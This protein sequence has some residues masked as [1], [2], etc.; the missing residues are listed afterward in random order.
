[1][2]KFY[3]FLLF[4]FT[5]SGFS[6]VSFWFEGFNSGPCSKGQSANATIATPTN[7]A[8]AITSF[9]L[10]FMNG[11]A[12][13]EWYISAEE[14]GQNV[15]VCGGVTCGG[16]NN[17]TLHMSS[18]VTSPPPP[19]ID[20]GT[21]YE[22]GFMSNTNK[23]AETPTVNCSAHAN[24]QLSFKIIYG[25]VPNFDYCDLEYS[26]N[27][28]I[29]WSVLT[30]MAAPNNSQ[31]PTIGTWTFYAYGLPPS[32]SNN[33][34]VKIGFHWY[35]SDPTGGDLSIGID[36]IE[37]SE[38]TMTTNTLVDCIAASSTASLANIAVGNTSFTWAA[39]PN[40]VTFTPNSGTTTA[41]QFPGIGTYTLYAYGSTANGGPA[42][43]TAISVVSVGSSS[44]VTAVSNTSV[45]CQGGSAV[46][47][48]NGA[49]TYTWNTSAT[50]SSI[51]VSPSV[52]TTYTVTGKN[53]Y[54]VTTSTVQQVVDP[55]T[56]IKTQISA[57]QFKIWPNPFSNKITISTFLP[58]EFPV[59]IYN[60]LGTLI[61]SS[62]IE[63]G[64]AEIDMSEHPNGIYFMRIGS[65]IRKIVKR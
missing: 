19:V 16:F 18:N 10:P 55:C 50:T 59:K 62:N 26:D 17:K 45:L 46:L 27:A 42:T 12:A 32:L 24:V 11:P 1:M 56:N 4:V 25:G 65:T 14:Q 37:F 40:T 8:W 28:G 63:N 6:Q 23:R 35:N 39:I 43:S 33:P 53:G 64:N 31:C 48:A 30:T 36:D 5:Y 21:D 61:Y 58:L 52:T 15:N 34:N 41:M 49:T 38:L 47:T 54:C 2:K 29:T 57:D 3:T 44:S 60:T 9:S 7:G 22:S 20:I 51:T 13:N